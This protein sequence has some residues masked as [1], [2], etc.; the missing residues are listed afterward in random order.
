M[1][2]GAQATTVA[3][4][5]STMTPAS[6]RSRS[7]RRLARSVSPAAMARAT[8]GKVTVQSI[9]DRTIGICATFCA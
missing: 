3:A 6:A 2:C 1:I 5:T 4:P 8:T 7:T 9:R